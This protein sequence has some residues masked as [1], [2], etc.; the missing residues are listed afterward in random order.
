MIA[1]RRFGHLHPVHT[2]NFLPR[3]DAERVH[4]LRQ[5]R[6]GLSG[7][8]DD[9][10]LGQRSRKSPSAR[11]RGSTRSC[12]S[13]AGSACRPAR[14]AASRLVPRERASH[15]AGRLGPPDGGDGGR[16]RH[17]AAPDLRQ[18]AVCQPPGDGRGPRRDPAAAA[19][20]AI[21]G[22]RPIGISLPRQADRVE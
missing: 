1:A 20:Q 8:G 19:G 15:H 17:A 3:T 7:G 21:N 5:V 4:R 11:P 9:A 18:P 10:G 6:R 14:R 22:A 2:T 16:A 12:V 13:A